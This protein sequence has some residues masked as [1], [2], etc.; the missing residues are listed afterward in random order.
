MRLLIIY[1]GALTF[2]AVAFSG[3]ISKVASPEEVILGEWQEKKWEYEMVYTK[4]DIEVLKETLSEDVKDQLGK[5]L[6]IHTAEKW[7]FL[8]DGTLQLIGNEDEKIVHWRLK[9]RGH[10]LELKYNDG[11]TEHYNL[12]LLDQSTMVLNFDSDIQVRGLAKLTFE[13]S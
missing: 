6:V 10:I 7:N 12:T 13:K 11:V 9:G 3:A 4:S 8:P 1:F 5:H 2:C